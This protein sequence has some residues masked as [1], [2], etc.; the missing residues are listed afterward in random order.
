MRVTKSYSIDRSIDAFL[1]KTSRGR[2]SVSDRVNELLHRA[3]EMEEERGLEIEAERFYGSVPA[4][5]RAETKAFQAAAK[6]SLA[7]D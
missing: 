5:E 4:E 2:R 1:R 6:A 3:I 7:Q